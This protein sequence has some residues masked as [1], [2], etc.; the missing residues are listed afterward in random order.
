MLRTFHSI[1]WI[2]LYIKLN[3]IGHD[4][5]S[6]LQVPL[7]VLLEKIGSGFQTMHILP[8]YLHMEYVFVVCGFCHDFIWIEECCWQ[9]FQMFNS[10]MTYHRACGAYASAA[11]EFY[12][13]NTSLSGVR[14]VHAVTCLHVFMLFVACC[15]VRYDFRLNRC[16]MHV[17]WNPLAL[18]GVHVLFTSFVFIY[19]F[20]CLRFL[21]QMMFLSFYGSTTGTTCGEETVNSCK[22]HE[23]TPAFSGVRV[24][25][26]SVFCIMLCRSLFVLL[27]LVIVLSVLRFI[28]LI[29]LWY[30]Q[31]FFLDFRFK[32]YSSSVIFSVFI[33]LF[34]PCWPKVNWIDEHLYNCS[35]ALAEPNVFSA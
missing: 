30:L 20:W 8:K 17:S 10:F 7:R 29:T 19:V 28:H 23:F 5:G 22:A 15:D 6:R 4:K 26:S 2:K 35:S 24:S 12:R 25:L 9:R 3:Y 33:S 31:T 1:Q 34:F 14:V 16:S 18:W 13:F 11:P 21:Y 27:L 32:F